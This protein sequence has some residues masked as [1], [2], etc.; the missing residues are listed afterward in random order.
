MANN[1]KFMSKWT[2]KGVTYT[3]KD[4][5]ARSRLDTVEQNMVTSEEGKGL[6]TN[7]FTD[8]YKT[9]VDETASS[10]GAHTSNKSNPHGVTASQVGLGNVTNDK[11]VK[12]RSSGTTAG[13]VVA[14]GAD[15][16]NLQD[17]GFT[18]GKSVPSDAEFTDTKY[19]HPTINA[20][21]TQENQSVG[22]G[23]TFKA[24]SAMNV[25]T[26]GH[27][28]DIVEKTFTL[29]NETEL[30]VEE[31]GSGDVIS[32]ISVSG[33]KITVTKNTALTADHE[34]PKY[35]NQNAFSNILVGDTILAAEN[36]TDVFEIAA[37]EN[38]TLTADEAGDTIT[39]AAKDTTYVDATTSKS[40]LM[41]ADDK[42][43]L[44]GIAEGAQVN[45]LTGVKGAAESS[46]R[47]GN[48][49]ITPANIGLGNVT[50]ESKET[51]FVNAALT[52]TPTA[53]T[54][55]ADTDS[56]QIATTAFVQ[57]VVSSKIA[58]A[59]AM[60]YKGTIGS[61]GATISALPATHKTGWSYKVITA[62]T[63]AGQKCEV[64]D[65]IICLN[66]GTAAKDSDWT[67]VQSNIDGAVIGPENSVDAHVATFDGATGKV[68][69]DSGFTIGTSV[70]SDAVFTDTTYSD[71]TTSKSGLMSAADKTR[72]N[73]IEEGAQVNQNAYAAIKV[74]N[75]TLSADSTEDTLTLIAGANVTLTPDENGDAVTIAATDM[76]YTHPT[77]SGN[78]LTGSQAPEHGGTFGVVSSLTLANGHVSGYIVD[79]VT[80]PE[81]TKLSK[82]ESG[83]GNAITDIAVNGHGIT[84][85][86]GKTFSES[87]HTHNYAGA[88]SSGGAATK[89]IN[90]ENGNPITG[91]VTGL[92]VSGKTITFNKGDGTSDTITT[93]D[94][95]YTHPSYS[96]KSAGLYKVTVDDM[97][98]VSAA[99]AVTKDDITGL[100]IPAQDTTYDVATTSANGLMSKD[101][102]SKLDGIA[103]G[104]Q[105][106]T[107]TGVKG[108]SESSYRTG[109]INITAANVG[110][111]NVTNESKATMFTSPTFT[112]TP[113][114]PTADSGTNTTQI[115][116]TAF[117]Q[118][119]IDS[120]IAAADAMIYKGTIG[121]SG[122]TV[123]AL[124]TTHKT[125]WS[126]KVITAGTYA[127]VAC[128]VGD[129]IICLT[130]GTANNNSDWTVVQTNIDGA[131]TGPAS[132]VANRVAVF[133][134][135]TGK[136]IKDSGYTIAK[137]VPSDAVF[138]DTVYTH[139]TYTEK[140]AGLY[141]VT[142][143]GTGH[144]S[145]ATAVTK[146]DITGLGI[147]AQD[148]TY[149][150][151]STSANG[152]M[153]KDDKS[154]LDGIAAGANA[155]THP[156]YTERSA[157][158]YKVTVD[159]TGHVSA[160]TAVTKDDITA[161]GIPAQ[162]TVY[163]LPA[164]TTSALGGVK[165][166]SNLT[167]AD[168]GTLSLVWQNITN[169]LGFVP[170]RRFVWTNVGISSVYWTSDTTYPDFPYKY[171]LP[172]SGI[173]GDW[174]A[175]VIFGPT[176][177]IS[178][179]FAPINQ[180]LD[181]GINLWATEVPADFTIPTIIFSY[182]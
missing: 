154:K 150:V 180:T 58:A 43:K 3:V 61:S 178:G 54:A 16:Y 175:E 99:T 82:S 133:N 76:T 29:P 152:L 14:W 123:T 166:G 113:K 12:G 37:G 120:K 1:T 42:T 156:S 124:P 155:Y 118:A 164:A 35:E 69:K 174:L 79:T 8:A 148:T 139:P 38:V 84:V 160:A 145:A 73:G 91:Y 151:A 111:G 130:D 74:G 162:D 85:T 176:E 32:G 126:Y 142:V 52:G 22:H 86:K 167:F 119:E 107:V 158:L 83:S 116:T 75:A 48:V 9:K 98:H 95:V 102:K 121:S 45:T 71:A 146:D 87:D 117:V 39:I 159:G 168:D 77:Y 31:S 78:K 97:G 104:A 94:T 33:H 181:G 6:S 90:D 147:P 66:D 5:E 53:P 112:G 10:L 138:T 127:G 171:W 100:G 131:V 128:E 50:N 21:T 109:N 172:V 65:L 153:S 89:A 27:V 173:T 141:K 47:I 132:S 28:T 88:A 140:S 135:T 170:V 19:T 15:G 105:V 20:E 34:H 182:G 108:N 163:S 26:E 11:Q 165:V 62:G 4:A 57:S 2:F 114:A 49:N 80:L 18:I 59:D 24:I 134:G 96:A 169:A 64:G 115:A 101:D 41:S 136:V 70:P 55:G 40:G 177:V 103:A 92:S 125:G 51:M 149:D 72:L 81:E 157:G 179:I 17:T 23:N 129:I 161:L 13:N 122:A 30:T 56:T 25:N 93:Q 137:S 60:I 106:N 67:V 110:L 44:N 46:Y 63:Y 144:V 68:I 7:D 143:D 36:T